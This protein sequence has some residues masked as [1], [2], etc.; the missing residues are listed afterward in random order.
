MK[1]KMV[2]FGDAYGSVKYLIYFVHENLSKYNE[3]QIIIFA[4]N[5]YEQLINRLN[6]DFWGSKVIT[7]NIPS[8][9]VKNLF[10]TGVIHHDN[11]T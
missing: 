6:R 2:L 3:I 4:S 1:R 5:N 10:W 9:A 8:C 11:I 7:H